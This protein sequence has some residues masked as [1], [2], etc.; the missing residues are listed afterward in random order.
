MKKILFMILSFIAGLILMIIPLP[1]SAHWLKPEWNSLILIFWVISEP[2]LA[3]LGL[4]WCLGILMDVLKGDLLGQ[5]ALAMSIIAFLAKAL[6][7]RIRLQPFWHQLLCILV[8]VG[9]GQL[10][11]LSIR[12]LIGYPPQTSLVWVSTLSSIVV[13]PLVF[14]ILNRYKIHSLLS[15]RALSR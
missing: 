9:L 3:G 6:G 13:W 14:R 7:P 2:Q 8:L 1:F 15:K 11:L 10:I 12:S 4:A 5:T